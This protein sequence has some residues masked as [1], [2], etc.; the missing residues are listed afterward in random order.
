MREFLRPAIVDP[1]DY[2]RA[3]AEGYAA[4]VAYLMDVPLALVA[5]DPVRIRELHGQLFAALYVDA[6]ALRTPRQAAF[7]G[8]RLGADAGDLEARLTGLHRSVLEWE[9]GSLSRP[10]DPPER[11]CF[12]ANYHGALIFL[13]PFRDGNGRLARLVSTWQEWALECEALYAISRG[14]Y[15]RGMRALPRD[16]RLLHNFFLARH[17]LPLT[18]VDLLEPIFPIWTAPSQDEPPSPA[19]PA[20]E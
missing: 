17:G 7:F 2:A 14:I 9:R 12:V 3:M 13:H 6:G 18:R 20:A 10:L 5:M 16:L 11:L 8:G 4:A 1:A 19:D 15:M